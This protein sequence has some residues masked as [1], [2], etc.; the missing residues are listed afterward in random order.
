MAMFAGAFS[1]ANAQTF[2]QTLN[3]LSLDA[4]KAYVNPIV[5]GFGVDL[6]GGWFH[7]APR[8]T[9]FGFD[10]EVGVVA[11]ETF[12]KDDAK[13]FSSNGVFAFDDQQAASLT[14]FVDK[15]PNYAPLTQ[16]QRDNIKLYIQNQITAQSFALG[17]SGPTI[18]GS[19]LD[20]VAIAFAPK[21]FNNVPGAPGG[22]VTVPGQRVVLPV[23][24]FLG[25]L[26]ALPL[27]APQLT[28]GTFV[29]SQFTFRYLPSTNTQNLG[30]ASYF[31]WGI[32]HNPAIWLGPVDVIPV[33]LSLSFF[34]QDLKVGTTFET[35]ATSFGI[36]VSKRLGWGFLNLTPYAG[37]MIEKSTMSFAYDFNAPDPANNYASTKIEHVK[38]DLESANKSRL[39][40]GLSFKLL[41][42]NINADYNI[43]KY[44]SA[45][46]GIM[47]II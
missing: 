26:K 32:Q 45:T 15:D 27:A 29:G 11:M 13:T 21:T 14:L 42:V 9:M 5:S 16:S 35:K 46:A 19:S 28:L 37:F 17:I 18:V 4:A 41:I 39:V 47:F 1:S 2:E 20:S 23:T 34:T 30:K 3:K 22:T 6:N 7:R 8:T 10:L 25:E 44:N 24:G 43:G 40:L 12:F 33:D 38:F 31:G 36:N